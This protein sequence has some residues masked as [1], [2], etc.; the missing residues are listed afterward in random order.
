MLPRFH[1]WMTWSRDICKHS[2]KT[3]HTV[4]SFPAFSLLYTC[5]SF[6]VRT[7]STKQQQTPY[8]WN[9][10]YRFQDVTNII[11]LTVSKSIAHRQETNSVAQHSWCHRRTG[12]RSPTVGWFPAALTS[13]CPSNLR[14]LGGQWAWSCQRHSRSESA[15][16]AKRYGARTH[17]RLARR[18]F[19]R[20]FSS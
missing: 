3:A 8:I 12:S 7:L 15:T 1:D 16:D 13:L 14:R 17:H 2:S 19:R 9:N 18:E 20:K 4:L 11:S 10:R 5:V 6:A